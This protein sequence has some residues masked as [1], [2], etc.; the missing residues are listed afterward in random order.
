MG[1]T[2]AEGFGPASF[3]VD[4]EDA[5]K[6]KSIWNDD[7][8]AGSYHVKP[9]NGKNQKLINVSAGTWEFNKRNDVTEIMC[10]DV[11]ATESQP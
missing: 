10:N 3:W 9:S 8:E 2:G 1:A 6:D 4:A 11:W 5:G 7:C